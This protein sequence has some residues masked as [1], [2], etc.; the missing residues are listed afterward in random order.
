MVDVFVDKLIM[1]LDISSVDEVDGGYISYL[2]I[3]LPQR[4]YTM[5]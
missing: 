5:F 1:Y 3:D 2:M 4:M